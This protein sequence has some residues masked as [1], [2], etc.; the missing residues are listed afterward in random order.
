MVDARATLEL[1]DA[2]RNRWGRD[3]LIRL[4]EDRDLA[5]VFPALGLRTE[6][7]I[8]LI[9]S[10]GTSGR[11]PDGDAAPL[12]DYLRE[13]VQQRDPLR[14][15]CTELDRAEARLKSSAFQE[16]SALLPEGAD[17]GTPRIVVVP[18]G[19][20]FR[21]DRNDLYMDPL[22]ALALGLEG[23]RKTWAHEF[24][25]IA[26]YRLTGVNLSLMRPDE[27]APP[28][29]G[30]ALAQEWA[31]WLEAEGIADCVSNMTETD[32]PAL[33][34][35]AAERRRQMEGYGELLAATCARLRGE[36][37]RSPPRV[38]HLLKLRSELR[39]SAHPVGARVARA[40]LDEHGRAAL[41]ACVGHP[42]ELVR[43]YEEVAAR[44]GLAVFD[45]EVAS[46]L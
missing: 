33:R 37:S 32:V 28:S 40:V 6:L 42:A 13:L 4:F 19:Y 9:L 10:S 23:I 14:R 8:E 43:R 22:A 27:E 24:H 5:L 1:I 34:S 35:A 20:D 30:T 11:G 46:A 15:L 39:G 7:G 45:P 31:T 25:H 26:R 29:A 36:L 17:L 21:T 2:V 41:A 18:L 16:T 38:D 3:R 12:A 44:R